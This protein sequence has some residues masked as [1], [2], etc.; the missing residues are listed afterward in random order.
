LHANMH[1][2]MLAIIPLTE[3]A[4]QATVSIASHT[5]GVT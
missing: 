3:K 4:S 1:R 2:C 5:D